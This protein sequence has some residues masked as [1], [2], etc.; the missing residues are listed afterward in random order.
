MR[1]TTRRDPLRR[2]LICSL[3]TALLGGCVVVPL[4]SGYD[5]HRE[6]SGQGFE[7]RHH[8][9][10]YHPYDGGFRNWDHGG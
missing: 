1:T 3:L 2:I 10:G 4:N 6:R 9:S 8:D 7:E 5:G